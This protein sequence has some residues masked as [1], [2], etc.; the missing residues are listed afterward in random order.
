M[1]RFEIGRRCAQGSRRRSYSEPLMPYLG[2]WQANQ[3]GIGCLGF[4]CQQLINIINPKIPKTREKNKVHEHQ[5]CQVRKRFQGSKKYFRDSRRCGPTTTK[6][7]E[8][9]WD[10]WRSP[11][12]NFGAENIGRYGRATLGCL[13]LTDAEHWG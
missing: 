11:N 2:E 6:S 12:G 5:E 9:L 4:D 8:Y 13:T 3:L 10:I 7:W 1:L